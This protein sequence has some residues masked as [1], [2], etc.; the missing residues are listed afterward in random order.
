MDT[1][2][3]VDLSAAIEG[4]ANRILDY[5]LLLAA[6]GT[7]SM[8]LIELIKAVTRGRLIFHRL[9]VTRWVGGNAQVLNELLALAIG[10]SENA[11]AF[12]D[13]PTA[14]MLGQ[15]Q[16]ASNVALDFPTVYPALYS[17]LSAGSASVGQTTDEARWRSFAPRIAQGVPTDPAAK[18]QFEADSR[19]STQARARL[20]NLVTRRLDAFQTRAEYRWARL[21]QTLAVIVGV[22]LSYYVLSTTQSVQN[23]NSATLVAVSLLGGLVAPFAKDIVTALSGLRTRRT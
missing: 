20:G 6:I 21:N 14:K 2:N 19:E 8:A 10:G 1:I 5:A 3:L 13:Q 23:I 9:M 11:N 16:A 18:A 22:L 12:Y 15:L 4:V 17:F 7:I